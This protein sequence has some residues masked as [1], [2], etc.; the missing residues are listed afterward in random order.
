[1][2]FDATLPSRV[3]KVD[4]VHL[5]QR[6]RQDLSLREVNGLEIGGPESLEAMMS[7]YYMHLRD[8][9]GNLIEDNEGSDLPSLAVARDGAMRDMQELLGEAIRHGKDDLVFEAVIIADEQGRHVASVPIVAALPAAIVDLLK[10]P[11]KA[12]PLNRFEEY[13]RNADGCRT[14]A[15]KAHDPDDKMSWLKLADGWLQMLPQH[16]ELPGWPKAS[17]ED[18]KASH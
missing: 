12:I 2:L 15:E 8:F 10:Q 9:R 11:S 1:M 7:R 4:V 6:F 14:M 16:E 5:L 3:R 18:S 13:R 17:E